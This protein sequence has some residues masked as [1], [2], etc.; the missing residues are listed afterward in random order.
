MANDKGK[1]IVLNGI[2]AQ[3][4]KR[5]SQDDKFHNKGLFH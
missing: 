2:N 5:N 4:N 3:Y 1:W